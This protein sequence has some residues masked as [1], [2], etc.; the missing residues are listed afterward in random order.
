MSED[1]HS[2][3]AAGP[4]TEREAHL[5]VLLMPLILVGDTVA[6]ALCFW[7][8][9]IGLLVSVVVAI[10]TPIVLLLGIVV[11]VRFWLNFEPTSNPTQAKVLYNDEWEAT[12]VACDVGIAPVDVELGKE[13]LPALSD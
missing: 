1:D 4:L 3:V 6:F 11:L 5:L 8:Y 2:N 12:W 9:D 10:L 13:A 7:W